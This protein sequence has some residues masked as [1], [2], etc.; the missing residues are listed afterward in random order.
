L[1]VAQWH[2]EEEPPEA[3]PWYWPCL[4]N[5][6]SIPVIP[7]IFSVPLEPAPSASSLDFAISCM[8]RPQIWDHPCFFRLTRPGVEPH[9]YSKKKYCRVD[10][11]QTGQFRA[12]LK[13]LI[14][15]WPDPFG[16]K[17]DGR[18]P[19]ESF[20]PTREDGHRV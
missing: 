4:H 10:Y 15:I 2:V 14:G 16:R 7:R 20:L 3:W 17:N 11:L 5:K 19:R 8:V 13:W 6:M 12:M 9:S 1:T 18:K